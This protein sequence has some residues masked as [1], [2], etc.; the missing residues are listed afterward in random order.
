MEKI[1]AERL[2]VG[3]I[4]IKKVLVLLGQSRY[5]VLRR[6]AVLTAKGFEKMGCEVT[7]ADTVNR[8]F[9]VNILHDESYDLIF[10][11]QAFLFGLADS[12]G[13]ELISTIKTKIC[14]WIFDD[15]LFHYRRVLS[16]HYEHVMLL[17]VDGSA[18]KIMKLMKPSLNSIQSMLHGGFISEKIYEKKSIDILCP[19]T[20]GKKPQWKSEPSSLE[21]ELAGL[22]INKWRVRPDISA[23]RAIEE[24][25]EELGEKLDGGVLTG[26]TNPVIYVMDSMRYICRKTILETL[27]EENFKVHL[28]GQQDENEEYPENVIVH[29]PMDIDA[30]VELF[31]QSKLVINPFPCVYEEGA[32]ERIFTA[33]LNRAV[34]FTPGY[35]FL[36][37]LLGERI[38]YI[39]LNDM[40]DAV[41]R[42]HEII[43]NYDFYRPAIEDNYSYALEMHSWEK[44]GREIIE[45]LSK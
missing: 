10:M 37:Q 34:C 33:L 13:N 35:A 43:D 44:R 21:K 11:N 3:A 14:G 28:I 24:V 12:K 32:H 16:N 27:A 6:A 40:K 31:A 18:D 9:D 45:L 20:L 19:C 25:L 30:V 39:D 5:E 1:F 38:E 36:E 2:E 7:V 26:L 15:V 41:G 22:A 8:D 29:G 42:M 23:R 17:S 4:M